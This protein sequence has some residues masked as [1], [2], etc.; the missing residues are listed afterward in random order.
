MEPIGTGFATVD[1]ALGGLITGDNV[2]WIC[3]DEAVYDTLCAGFSMAAS[4]HRQRCIHVSFGG[5]RRLA[6]PGVEMLDAGPTGE[7]DRPATLADELDRRLQSSPPDYVVIDDLTGPARRWGI[8]A[9]IEFF[10][11]VC[12]SMLQAGVTAYWSIGPSLGR[13]AIDSIRQI[14][15]CLIDVRS[16]RLRVVKAEGRAEAQQAVSYRLSID[17]DEL[18]VTI[19]PAGGRLARGLVALRQEVGMTQLEL[20]TI[21]GVTASAIS[22]AESGSR[23]LSVDTLLRISDRLVVPLD[24][25]VNATPS[26]TYHLARHDRSRVLDGGVIAL[27]PDA[28]IGTRVYLVELGAGATQVPTIDHQGLEVIA[29]VSGL[30]QIDLGEDRPVLRCGDTLVVETASVQ[31]WRNLRRKPARFFRVLRD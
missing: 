5:D 25:L 2:V 26:P 27:V 21:A 12:P 7:F 17:G 19:A 1:V 8:D 18:A 11:R 24:R 14:T 31:S 23:G 30:V 10:S 6:A 13:P 20:A 28:S 29:V 15:Q 22:Q 16:G 3:D 4:G 9:T